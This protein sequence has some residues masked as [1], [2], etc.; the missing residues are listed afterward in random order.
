MKAIKHIVMASLMLFTSLALAQEKQIS[1]TVTFNGEPIPG[2]SVLIKNTSVGTASDFDGNYTITA[3]EGD[4]LVFSYVGF[5]SQE[6]PVGTDSRIDVGLVEDSQELEEVVLIGYGAVKK[7]DLSSAISTVK[8]EE[9]SKRTVT[10]IQ[11]AL[12][13]QLPGVQ[14][15]SSGGQPGS[16]GTVTIR[17]LSTLNDNTPLYVVDDVPLDDINFLLPDDIESVQVLKDASASAI[18]GSRAS[19]GVIIIRTKQARTDRFTVNINANGGIQNVAKKPSLANASEYG[20]IINASLEN[21]GNLPLYPNPEELGIGTDWWDE[22]TQSAPMSNFNVN[23]TSGSETMKISTG[24]S[25]QYQDGIIKGSDF[26]KWNVRLNTEFKLG[27]KVTIGE[28][29]TLANSQTTNG[30]NLVWDVHRLEPVTDPFLPD[31]EQV[32]LNEFSIFSPTITDVPNALGQLARSFNDDNYTRVVGNFFINWEI[33]EGLSFKSQYNIYFSSFE[34]NWFEPDY[35]IE[36]TDKRDVN[37]VS[38]THNNRTNTTW[39]NLVTYQKDFDKHHLNVMGGIIVESREHRTLYGEGENVPNN[40]PSLRYLDAATEA[41]FSSGNNDKY[42]LISYLGRASYDFDN[43]YLVTATVRADGSSLFPEENQWAVFPSISAGWVISNESFMDD[44]NWINLLKLRAGYGQIGND[45]RNSL[46]NSAKLTTIGNEFYTSGAGQNTLIGQAPDNVGN[47]DLLWET[48]EDI[49]FG[50]DLSF[51]NSELGVNLDV[52]SRTTTDMI[53]EK[54]IPLYLGAGFIYQW[55]NVGSFKTNGVDLGINYRHDFN[56]FKTNFIL[57]L[58]HYKAK[59]TNLA[60]GEAIW[61]GNHQRLNSLSRTAEGMA[62]G[63]FY[64]YVADGI[65]QN[66]TEI[67][68]HSDEFGNII[69]PFAQP[70]DMRFKDL[71]GDGQLTDDDRTEIGNP[72]PDFTF[73]FTM[74]FE[75]KGFDLSTLFT[76]SY[77]G[78]M[79]NAA[80]PYLNSGAGNYNSY[81]GLY[82]A[83]WNGEGSTNVQP[84]L[85][86]D[87]PNQ[88]FRYSSYYIEDGSF[89]RLRNLQFGYRLSQN[90]LDKMNLTNLRIFLTGE[91]IFTATSF[92]G[93]DPDIGGTATLQGVDWGH[94]PL[95]RI[96]NIGVN[97]AF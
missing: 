19:N 16:E 52:Y 30:P 37:K 26:Q 29:F 66:R 42:N 32:G 70:G 93:L 78:D 14:V 73:G 97:I 13:G 95:P 9:L 44:T 33:I 62:P 83:A 39:N 86:N 90:T 87:D 40:T 36:E 23:I 3:S 74:K 54:S 84:R 46:P 57:N 18:F 2:V 31:Y 58:T 60:D 6:I 12:A 59:V 17:G 7:K 24:A 69:Q 92:S 22:V 67:N 25:H 64:G 28:N 43:K 27:E 45:N 48:V 51:F 72:I 76:G 77:G 5:A 55:A 89:I 10:N 96:F 63:Q 53:M 85:S 82:D 20:R 15:Q 94:Y 8:G 41:F 50:L 34:N 88:N 68:S 91:N 61:D 65:F 21:D 49:N 35:Y 47:P 56:E 38:R 71:N 81:A 79:L 80:K 75:Y 1:G 4:I 11:D